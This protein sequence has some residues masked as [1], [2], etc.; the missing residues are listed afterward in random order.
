[1]RGN[2]LVRLGLVDILCRRLLS[3]CVFMLF[4]GLLGALDFGE[5]GHCSC[6]NWWK[7]GVDKKTDV[8]FED[9]KPKREGCGFLG[10]V[11]R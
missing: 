2:M 5:D 1:M 3:F 9:Y 7:S 6:L 8:E 10:F 4:G 11:S